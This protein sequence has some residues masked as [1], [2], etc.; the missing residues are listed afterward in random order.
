MGVQYENKIDCNATTEK[1]E[2]E[3]RT[4]VPVLFTSVCVSVVV[5]EP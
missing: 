3:R 1:T 5:R 2:R 4:D